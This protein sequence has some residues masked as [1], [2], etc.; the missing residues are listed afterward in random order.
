MVNK[1]ELER[2]E[3]LV[4]IKLFM[5]EKVGGLA[6]VLD[7]FKE[8]GISLKNLSTRP[9]KKENADWEFVTSFVCPS[10]TTATELTKELSSQIGHDLYVAEAYD[11]VH[12]SSIDHWYP[13]QIQEID[14]FASRVLSMG[15]DLSS[16][17][18]GAK[19]PVYRAR[20]A[21]LAEIAIKYSHGEKIPHVEYTEE[22]RKTWSIVF[23]NVEKMYETHACKEHRRALALMKESC[24]Y[25]KDTIPQLQTLSEFLKGCSGFTLRPVAGL[26]RPRDFLAGLAFRVFH[27][28]QYIRHGSV[29]LYTP[30]PD[31]CHEVLGHV[32]LF[33]D[34]DFAAFSQEIGLASLGASEEDIK[35]LEYNYWF[36]VE[37]GLVKEN[38]KPKAFG[39][40]LLSSFGELEYC[41]TDKPKILPYDPK[42]AQSVDHPIT[43]YQ[44]TYFLADSFAS[45]TVQF[46]NYAL[47]L[48]RPF[49]LR[50]NPYTQRIERIDSAESAAAHAKTIQDD[51]SA[52][53]RILVKISN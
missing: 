40:G 24:G 4:T 22:E 33:A 50:Y 1:M 17:H 52:L 31:I 7:F 5:K 53:T 20:R 28:T 27:S 8:K 21:E 42:V 29:P 13:Q 26:L 18:P 10:D 36:T 12:D 16:D 44:P 23:E 39:A 37:F 43:E 32:P 19:D 2:D 30:E 41:L 48:S 15:K 45:A 49:A 11:E 46:R 35:K 47:G 3:N 25:S 6:S 38:G 14:R 9:A 51:M 34:P